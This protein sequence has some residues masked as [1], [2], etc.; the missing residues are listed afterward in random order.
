MVHGL[1]DCKEN[2]TD[3]YYDQALWLSGTHECHWYG[4]TCVN[5]IVREL[6]LSEFP[7]ACIDIVGFY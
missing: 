2:K 5:K 6:D 1:S 3:G 7:I 4:V